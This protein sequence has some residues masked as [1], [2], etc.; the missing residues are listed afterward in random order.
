MSS[1][2]LDAFKQQLAEQS[3]HVLDYLAHIGLS[4]RW[5]IE[6]PDPDPESPLAEVVLATR[7]AGESLAVLAAERDESLREVEEKLE[8]I[9]LQARAILE[10]STP[11]IQIW[12]GIL[13]LPLI[14]TIDSGRAAQIME[15]L[16]EAVLKRRASVVI[17]DLTGVPVVDTG[18][19][20]H[21]IQT[22][23]ATRLLGAET[24]LT[25]VSS[26]NAQTLVR[27]GV[28]LHGV[29]TRSSLQSG[30]QRAFELTALKVVKV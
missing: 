5:D 24:L 26:D 9:E 27:L 22:V 16:L 21:L 6:I 30:L 25:G 3:A 10:L 11:V 14:G 7:F 13:V 1:S 12:D 29:T 19:A 4:A 20:N 28:D 17:L 15:S 18:V 8:T 23:Q 2:E